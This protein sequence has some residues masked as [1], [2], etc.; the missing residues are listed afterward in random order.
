MSRSGCCASK[1]EGRRWRKSRRGC[2]TRRTPRSTPASGKPDCR[3]RRIFGAR[4]RAPAASG[5]RRAASGERRAASGER[6]CD[7]P[8]KQGF[9]VDFL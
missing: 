1:P 2:R 7:V 8:D 9:R 5:E 4:C 3:R 6:R